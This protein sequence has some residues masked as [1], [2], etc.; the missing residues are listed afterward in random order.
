MGTMVRAA[1][2]RGLPALIDE[3]GG[4]GR[5]LF[6][7]FGADAAAPAT[8]DAV[9]ESMAAGLILE[10][11]A[12]EL[13]CPDLGLRLA[14][15]Q[16]ISVLGPLSLAIESADTLGEALDC[17]TRFLF[18]HS[19]ALT[20]GQVGDPSGRPGV[21]ALCYGSTELEPMPPQSADLGLGLL[22]RSV[23]LLAG[24]R[25]GLRSVHLPHR[26]LAPVARYTEFFGA[27]VRFGQA[28]AL[29]RVPQ[30][31][32]ATPIAGGNRMLHAAAL[33]YLSSHYPAPSLSAAE[34]VE[35]LITQGLGSAPVDISAIARN[36]STHPRTL[37]RRLSAEGTGFEQILDSVRRNAAHRL[38]T[39]TSIPFTQITAMVGLTEQSALT[40]AVRRWFGSSPRDLRR[41]S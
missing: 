29:L 24:G 36:L 17:A 37:Q 3:L 33:D 25:Y 16:N 31:L 2:L 11:A 13:D 35:R 40:R 9:V 32:S 6:G 22:H 28:N 14:G 21:V 39:G 12:T 19:P 26:P 1:G 34:H 15:Q 27:D 18:V 10:A 8:D 38:I 41:S 7:R 4:D 5:E 23:T 20:V 30:A